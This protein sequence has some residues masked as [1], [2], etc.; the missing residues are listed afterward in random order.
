VTTV[1]GEPGQGEDGFALEQRTEEDDR[2][3]VAGE[4]IGQAHGGERKRPR[5]LAVPDGFTG[6]VGER[7][8][9]SSV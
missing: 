2:I 3:A 4:Q 7:A 5:Q 1:S 9:W 8:C 6:W